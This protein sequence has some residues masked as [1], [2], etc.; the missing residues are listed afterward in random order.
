MEN[1]SG[2][3]NNSHLNSAEHIQLERREKV[4]LEEK[5]KKKQGQVHGQQTFHMGTFDVGEEE[6]DPEGRI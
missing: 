2:E 1:K 5:Q 6:L 4:E 3:E